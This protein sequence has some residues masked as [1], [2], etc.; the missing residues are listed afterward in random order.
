MLKMRKNSMQTRT[1]FPRGGMDWNKALTTTFMPSA[2][3]AMRIG[4]RARNVRKALRLSTDPDCEDPPMLEIWSTR[5]MMTMK[6]SRTFQGFLRYAPGCRTKPITMIFSAASMQ[7]R[8]TKMVSSTLRTSFNRTA[9]ARPGVSSGMAIFSARS[10]ESRARQ[11]DD[12]T[13]SPMMVYSKYLWDT[14]LFMN[15]RKGFSVPKMKR[16]RWVSSVER[17]PG[18]GCGVELRRRRLRFVFPDRIMLVGSSSVP[19]SSSGVETLCMLAM[20][21][22]GGEFSAKLSPGTW[23]TSSLVEKL[24]S[25]M[26]KNRLRMT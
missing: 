8:I 16:L 19:S 10:S 5:P 14:M 9:S 4:R 12:I 24:S 13:I 23:S 11:R 1:T 22:L 3:L 15:N 2:R 20:S 25:K 18:P 17:T 21:S 7:K 6:K 26:A